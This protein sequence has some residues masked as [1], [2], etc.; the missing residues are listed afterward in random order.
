MMG[1]AVFSGNIL[2]FVFF[3]FDLNFHWKGYFENQA[4]QIVLLGFLVINSFRKIQI[5]TSRGV[6][7]LT[8]GEKSVIF[9]Q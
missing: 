6:F 9:I 5:A 1:S 7:F 8:H 4:L 2:R 3:D